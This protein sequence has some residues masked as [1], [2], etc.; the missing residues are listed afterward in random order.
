VIWT[1]LVELVGCALL[2]A[3]V[4]R[5]ALIVWPPAGAKLP[6]PSTVAGMPMAGPASVKAAHGALSRGRTAARPK[7]RT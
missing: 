6:D 1:G 5:F 4:V 2:V 3:G 7:F